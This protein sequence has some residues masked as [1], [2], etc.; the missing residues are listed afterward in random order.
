MTDLPRCSRTQLGEA[1][2]AYWQELDRHLAPGFAGLVVDKLPMNMLGLPLI[3]S[4]FPGALVIFA[5]RHPADAVLSGFMQSFVLNDT[6][7]SF[8]DIHDAADLYDAA[9]SAFTR[10]RDHVGLRVHTSV[11]ERLVEDP[12]GSLRA[13]VDLLG[14][15]W[16]DELLDHQR[17]ARQRGAIVTPSYDQVVRPLSRAPSG[18]WRRYR[19]Q[20]EPVL[21]VLL[22]WAQRLGYPD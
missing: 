11:Y 17:T 7:A 20:L 9:M 6:M 3:H 2:R 22:P 16:Q 12:E 18:R 19:K 13:L 4:L 21:S 1:R 10:A 5:Q 8:L 15:E 14:L